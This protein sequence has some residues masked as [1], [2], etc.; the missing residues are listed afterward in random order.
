[1]ITLDTSGNDGIK[2]FTL[3]LEDSIG[4]TSPTLYFSIN[5][6]SDPKFLI[7]YKGLPFYE[8]DKEIEDYT[9][10]PLSD[11]DFNSFRTDKQELIANKLL[12]TLFFNYPHK[13]LKEK[14]STGTFISDLVLGLTE[15]RMDIGSLETKILDND[16]FSQYEYRE[17]E[18]VNILTRFYA[19]KELDLYYFNNWMA[20]ILT[21]TIMFSPA[22]ELESSHS[23]NIARVYNRLVSMM[24]EEH[25]IRYINYIH[26]M[27]DDNWRRFRSPEDNGREMLEIFTYDTDD[28]HVPIAGKALQNWKL[29]SDND[30][31]VV[32][33]NH[34]REPLKL[35]DTII[36]SGEDFYRELS[37]SDVFMRGVI[38]RLVSFFFTT[39]GKRKQEKISQAIYNSHPQTWKDII[40]QIIL[41][42]EYLINTKRAKSIEELFFSTAKKMDFQL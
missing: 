6:V 32:S 21:Q 29:D 1:L 24:G 9:L 42:E 38:Q 13:V 34:N 41:S 30:T 10:K 37:K 20:Y 22:Y 5:K 19:M 33:L 25:S 36:Y 8:E 17:Q 11:S 26:M 3:S 31:L 18:A 40:L 35:F 4:N 12:S 27:S 16:I 28:A 39:Q 15:E 23:P 2:T 14:M 7:E